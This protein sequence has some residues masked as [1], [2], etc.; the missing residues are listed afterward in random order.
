MTRMFITGGLGFLG[1]YTAKEL[2]GHGHEVTAYDACF[3]YIEPQKSTYRAQLDRRVRALGSRV[4]IIRG[5]T[6]DLTA[7]ATALK[8]T[9]PE[10]VVHLA[11]VPLATA[12]NKFSTEAIQVNLY[13]TMALLEVMRTVPS[14]RRVVFVSSSFVYGNFRYEPADEEHP[15]DPIDVYGG[16]KLSGEALVKGYARRFGIEFVIVRPS[17]V[18]GPTDA[19][20]RVTQIFIESAI[21]GRPLILHDGGQSRL[22]FTYCEDAARGFVL[23]ALHPAAANEVF[24]ITRGEGRSIRELAEVIGA[25]VPGTRIDSQHET[26]KRPERGT[27]DISKARRV[28]GYE[29]QISLEEGMKRYVA[30]VRESGI[31]PQVPAGSPQAP[32]D[33]S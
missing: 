28:L 12:A 16:T 5:D 20:R 13:G 11:A 29:P 33:P 32:S 25:L 24:N 23:A 3:N 10:V 21:T 15:T 30:Y 19:N 2:L 18:Y 8:D 1:F 31:L 6:R 14:V 17:S 26:E 27:L 7:L 4:R 22:D 9:A